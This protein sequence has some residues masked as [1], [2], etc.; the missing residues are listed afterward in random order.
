MQRTSFIPIEGHGRFF[1]MNVGFDAHMKLE[2]ESDPEVQSE[3]FDDF[4]NDLRRDVLAEFMEI[5]AQRKLSHNLDDCDGFEST[6]RL[7]LGDKISEI[8]FEQA[9]EEIAQNT[10]I[11]KDLTEI[12]RI[13]SC[14][15]APILAA[16]RYRSVY[17]IWH[18]QKQEY[19][20]AGRSNGNWAD[21]IEIV[22]HTLISQDE[23]KLME[24]INTLES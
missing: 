11:G 15:E 14:T 3:A 1:G 12:N 5:A 21:E 7:T 4:V 6:H 16:E 17:K 2:F 10:R 23:E 9:A 8:A 22:A 20:D 24:E 19:V 18:F 13:F